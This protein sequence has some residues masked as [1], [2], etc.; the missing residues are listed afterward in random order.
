MGIRASHLVVDGTRTAA[1]AT[2]NLALAKAIH[3][4][5]GPTLAW[6]QEVLQ[7]CCEIHEAMLPRLLVSLYVPNRNMNGQLIPVRQTV[8]ALRREISRTTGGQT[9]YQGSGDYVTVS[10]VDL[11]EDTAV[12]ETFLPRTITNRLRRR[13]IRLFVEFGQIAKQEVVLVAVGQSGYWI[14]TAHLLHVK[15]DGGGLLRAG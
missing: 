10:G 3:R 15:H 5:L 2:P 9:T 11:D 13:L 1:T 14:P 4:T 8:R 7:E 12:I 6:S